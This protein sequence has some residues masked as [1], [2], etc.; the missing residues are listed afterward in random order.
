M[1]KLN[2][3]FRDRSA[4]PVEYDGVTFMLKPMS[5]QLMTGLALYANE[6]KEGFLSEADKKLFVKTHVVG[7]SDIFDEDGDEVE[8]SQRVALEY[9]THDDYDD[10]LMLLYWKSI[11]LSNEEN[12]VVEENKEIAKK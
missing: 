4:K 11:E 9:L 7:W 6:N 8:Y 3:G 2:I 10:L 1:K 5:Q 12:K